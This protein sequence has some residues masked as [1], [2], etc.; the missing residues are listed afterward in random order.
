MQARTTTFC[1]NIYIGL[2]KL[3]I[4]VEEI[5]IEKNEKC[6]K[7][8]E[9]ARNLIQKFVLDFYVKIYIGL[10]KLNIK[11]E[12]CRTPEISNTFLSF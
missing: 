6:L 12:K 7:S 3:N 5:E 4:E 2:L 8:S 1:V 10:L 11:E 9:I